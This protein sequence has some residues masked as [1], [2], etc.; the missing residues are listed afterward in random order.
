MILLFSQT[1]APL[2]TPLPSWYN[3]P[4][5]AAIKQPLVSLHKHGQHNAGQSP[6]TA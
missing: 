5:T 1:K 4:S 3:K 2:S 6:P